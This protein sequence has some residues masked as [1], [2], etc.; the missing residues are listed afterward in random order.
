MAASVVPTIT[1]NSDRSADFAGL[2]PFDLMQ[3]LSTDNGNVRSLL[4]SQMI[5]AMNEVETLGWR[6]DANNPDVLINFLVETSSR[7]GH[8][9]AARAGVCAAAAVTG[10]GGLHHVDADHRTDNSRRIVDRYA[11]SGAKPIDLVRCGA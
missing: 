10:C 6:R 3:P 8:G 9:Q 11:R 4:S 1:T 5:V 2:R 7:F